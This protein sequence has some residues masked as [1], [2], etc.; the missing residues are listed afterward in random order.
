MLSASDRLGFERDLQAPRQ[1]SRKVSILIPVMSESNY[2]SDMQAG[3]D[4]TAATKAG[5][6]ATW[7]II[8]V[9][10]LIK[11]INQ[12]LI[13][14]GQV[15]PGVE[16]GDLV[17]STGMKNAEM[18]EEAYGNKYHYVY[19]DAE[20]WRIASLV[21]GGVGQREELTVACKHFTPSV[22]RLAGY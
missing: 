7:K 11:P 19:A 22:F 1:D 3:L 2:D 10:A 5:R 9:A 8:E 21:Y 4:I 18:V 6:T 15:P 16:V 13:T 12:S 17:F 14:F 20:T